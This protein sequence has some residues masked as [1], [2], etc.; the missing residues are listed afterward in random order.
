VRIDP[1]SGHVWIG[2]GDGALAAIDS[3]GIKMADVPLRAH[4]E[5]FQ[6]EK[7]GSRIFVNLPNAKKVAVVDRNK[8]AVIARWSNSSAK[9]CLTTVARRSLL[10]FG[11]RSPGHLL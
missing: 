4:P 8:S 1:A 11:L 7:S 6:I 2:Y 3:K 9:A 10:L 5:S